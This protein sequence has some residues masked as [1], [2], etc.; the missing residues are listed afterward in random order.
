MTYKERKGPPPANESREL[1]EILSCSNKLFGEVDTRDV[2]HKCV[3]K[4]KKPLRTHHCKSCKQDIM[5]M[6][7][8]CRKSSPIIYLAWINNCVGVTN[9]GNF[10]LYI[11]YLALACTL[12]IYPLWQLEL[13]ETIQDP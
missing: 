13:P 6:D 7:H 2:C 3:H 9:H 10:V 8:H 12:A 5:L 11:T 4:P 1:K